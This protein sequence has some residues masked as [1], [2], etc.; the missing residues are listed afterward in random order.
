MQTTKV[1]TDKFE[2]VVPIITTLPPDDQLGLYHAMQ[3]PN[4]MYEVLTMLM[5]KLPEHKQIEFELLSFIDAMEFINAWIK[6]GWP[7]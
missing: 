1:S 6:A 4:A 2:A 5:A 7:E 3:R